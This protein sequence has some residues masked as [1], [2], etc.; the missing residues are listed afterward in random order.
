MK[1]SSFVVFNNMHVLMNI[2]DSYNL[3]IVA[4]SEAPGVKIN[5]QLKDGNNI[6]MST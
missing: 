1:K 5:K 2:V 3:L 6:I 4:E